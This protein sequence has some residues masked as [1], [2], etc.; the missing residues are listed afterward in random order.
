MPSLALLLLF[1]VTVADAAT[2]SLYDSPIWKSQ[3]ICGRNCFWWANSD[4][5][6]GKLSCDIPAEEAC[7]CRAD[8]QPKAKSI[9]NSCIST[10]CGA[11]Y[12][13]DVSSA[14]SIYTAYCLGILTTVDFEPPKST[15]SFPFIPITPSE[16]IFAPTSIPYGNSPIISVTV[17]VT[18]PVVTKVLVPSGAISDRWLRIRG[19]E[20]T[21]IWALGIV[22]CSLSFSLILST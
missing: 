11:P 9:L 20:I 10:E 5:L 13:L 19:A 4:W 2:Q 8:L 17:E 12:T 15:V 14:T 7:Y 18:G 16:S 22:F 6:A 3:R 1:L 21:H